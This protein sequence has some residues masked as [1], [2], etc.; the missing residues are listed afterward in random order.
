MKNKFIEVKEFDS[1]QLHAPIGVI[2]FDVSVVGA[3]GV[4]YKGVAANTQFDSR[5]VW[6]SFWQEDTVDNYDFCLTYCFDGEKWNTSLSG[7]I[8][9]LDSIKMGIPALLESVGHLLD[10]DVMED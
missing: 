10:K 1:F 3:D 5:D 6:T 2:V 7:I 8:N 4:A 9:K